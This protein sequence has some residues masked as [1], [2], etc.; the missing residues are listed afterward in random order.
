MNK[1]KKKKKKSW[2]RNLDLI[3]QY[4]SILFRGLKLLFLAYSSMG[5]SSIDPPY[6]P[7]N[8]DV[9]NPILTRVVLSLWVGL[10]YD[11]NL[12]DNT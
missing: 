10:R 3:S 4:Y 11:F 8:C 1:K 2:G 5:S 7:A 12:A 9:K 6:L